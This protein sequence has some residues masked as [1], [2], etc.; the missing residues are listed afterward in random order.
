MII[1]IETDG[2]VRAVHT[3]RFPLSD[4][5]P[6]KMERASTVE[7]NEVEQTWEVRWAGEDRVVFAHPR[8][9]VCIAWE[10]TVL[11]SLLAS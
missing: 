4:I 6:M 10:V 9:D 8:R 11:E 5:G 2:T 7:F 1:R 3:E